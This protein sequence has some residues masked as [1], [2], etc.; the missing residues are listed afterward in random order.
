M[1]VMPQLDD[2]TFS[3]SKGKSS[4]DL[5]TDID[6]CG[7]D[8]YSSCSSA[9]TDSQ[10]SDSESPSPSAHPR[11]QD[12]WSAVGRRVLTCLWDDDHDDMEH[13]DDVGRKLSNVFQSFND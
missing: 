10:Q 7:T 2:K 13:W 6:M 12:G 8:D 11:A 1:A 9:D 5:E 4:S 3:I